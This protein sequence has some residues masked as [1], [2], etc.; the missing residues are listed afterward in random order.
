M[1]IPPIHLTNCLR[2]SLVTLPIRFGSRLWANLTRT[3]AGRYPTLFKIAGLAAVSGLLYCTWW[4]YRSRT[5]NRSNQKSSPSPSTVEISQP[6]TSTTPSNEVEQSQVDEI[7]KIFTEHFK[8]LQDPQQAKI[9]N[10]NPTQP[11]IYLPDLKTI[12]KGE[13]PTFDEM[14]VFNRLRTHL[15]EKKITTSCIPMR[16]NQYQFTL[17]EEFIQKLKSG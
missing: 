11:V 8:W 1:S 9:H 12:C 3:S 17:H 14:R 15:Q 10:K 6:E 13:D 5:V 16:V 4:A 7:V 2:T